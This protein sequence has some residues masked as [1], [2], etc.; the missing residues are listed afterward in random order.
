MPNFLVKSGIAP[1]PKKFHEIWLEDCNK[2]KY[3]KIIF[4]PSRKKKR[5]NR[6]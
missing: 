6:R 4:D 5:E 2:K 3:S 1:V